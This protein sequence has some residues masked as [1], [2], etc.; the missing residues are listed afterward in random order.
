M[1]KNILKIVLFFAF[2]GNI[3]AQQTPASKQTTAISIE[4]ATA[5]L[6]NGQIIENSLVI[7]ENGKT[8]SWWFYFFRLVGL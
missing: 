7:F 2:V 8:W 1:M 6:G 4:G 3:V 5:H